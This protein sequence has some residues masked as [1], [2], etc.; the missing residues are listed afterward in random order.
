MVNRCHIGECETL[1]HETY[2]P[3][4]LPNAVPYL[5]GN[6][7]KCLRFDFIPMPN[8]TTTSIVDERDVCPMEAFDRT[9]ILS[10]VGDQFVYRSDELTIMNEVPCSGKE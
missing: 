3:D 5:H 6:P 4:W 8:G 9:K 7:S 2:E 1:N 10:C